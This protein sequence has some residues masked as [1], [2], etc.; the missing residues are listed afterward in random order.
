[1]IVMSQ[2]PG[3][4]APSGGVA[5]DLRDWDLAVFDRVRP[6]RVPPAS[7]ASVSF[8]AGLPIPGISV[9]PVEGRAG[10]S[11][12]VSWQ[13]T[14]PLLRYVSI[15]SLLIAPPV[16]LTLP[17]ESG[18]G[19]AEAIA[20][21]EDGPI[22]GVIEGA[23]GGPSAAGGG[24]RRA[25]VAFEVAQSNWGPDVSFP[26]FLS[27]AVEYLTMRGQATAGRFVRT[28]EPVQATPAKGAAEVVLEGPVRLT[29]GVRGVPPGAGE[30][31][32]V[33][34]FGQVERAGVY[35]LTGAGAG[36]Q[37][38]AVNLAD[39]TET[40]ARTAS[41]LP[42]AGVSRTTEASQGPNVREIWH[43]FVAV[44]LLLLVTEWFVQVWKMKA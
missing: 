12:V 29:A 1:M 34:S 26:V 3:G 35:R 41:D 39:E 27:N 28:S 19:N 33:V 10:T 14:H 32:E 30:G 37:V 44:A 13:R 31:S 25:L 38:V 24:A 8:G 22:V 2:A 4:G 11:R 23:G 16:R 20:W 18:G 42:L 40:L 9:G 36:P 21:G 7:L 17:T 43:W 15:D 6:E 5:P